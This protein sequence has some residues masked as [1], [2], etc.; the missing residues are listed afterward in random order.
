MVLTLVLCNKQNRKFLK[1]S[2]DKTTQNPN[3][4]NAGKKENDAP[5]TVAEPQ[6]EP[7]P[8]PKPVPKEAPPKVEEPEAES[9]TIQVRECH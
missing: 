2:A 4:G 7:K 8:T 3:G 9:D 1:E 5:E 6:P